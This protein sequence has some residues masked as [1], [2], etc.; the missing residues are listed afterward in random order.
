MNNQKTLKQVTDVI[1]IWE[2]EL[3]NYSMEKL[4][5]TPSQD[6]W[7]LGQVYNHLINT[8]LNF[9]L[10]QIEKC[11]ISTENQSKNKS[12]KGVVAYCI[13][14]SFPPIKVK[15]PPSDFYTSK[16]P[17][18]KQ[19]ILDGL[20]LVKRKMGEM[21]LILDKTKKQGKTPHPAFS[22]LN[23]NEWFKLIEMHFRHHLRQKKRLDN[24]LNN[25]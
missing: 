25:E 4:I 16:Q 6:S 9:H 2:N 19:E 13:L 18:S 23:G 21:Y 20:S 14:G 10:K 1:T 11:T 15:V 5:K 12:M 17:S 3:D 7:S 22:F 24:F 8:S